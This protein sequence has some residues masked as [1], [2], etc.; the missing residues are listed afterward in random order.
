[1]VNE[2]IKELHDLGYSGSRIAKELHIRKQTVLNEVREITGAEKRPFY[3]KGFEQETNKP[4]Q[5]H[6]MV[7]WAFRDGYNKKDIEKTAY[8][9][10]K[11]TGITHKQIKEM[12][13]DVARP[14]ENRDARNRVERYDKSKFEQKH[15][16]KKYSEYKK[17]KNMA[18]WLR[19]MQDFDN[20]FWDL[21]ER[22]SL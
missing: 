4:S 20:E 12:I 16:D 10:F 13:K 1:M 22:Y 3:F 18:L 7:E 14:Y 9:R 19:E 6:N 11:D 17:M 8:A 2:K 15:P 21:Y 5:A